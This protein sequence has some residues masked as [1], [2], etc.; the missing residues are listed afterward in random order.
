MLDVNDPNIFFVKLLTRIAR[1]IILDNKEIKFAGIVRDYET[2]VL[3]SEWTFTYTG[4]NII[5][6][7]DQ[8]LKE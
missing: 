3:D 7:R 1:F 5:T 4:R 2:Y 6:I 8:E